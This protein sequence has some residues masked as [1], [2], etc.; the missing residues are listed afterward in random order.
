MPTLLF[1]PLVS[2]V[3][4]VRLDHLLLVQLVLLEVL[5]FLGSSGGCRCSCSL[6]NR[7]R[8]G[9]IPQFAF[10]GVRGP[11][12]FS[13]SSCPCRVLVLVCVSLLALPFVVLVISTCLVL[14]F[15]FRLF[16]VCSGSSCYSCYPLSL[17]SLCFYVDYSQ[18]SRLR[19]RLARCGG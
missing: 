6:G 7:S 10:P 2:L 11:A 12:R 15:C 3:F 9:V 4:L 16:S 8:L 13:S 18:Y 1:L 19:C 5:V 17:L 14:R